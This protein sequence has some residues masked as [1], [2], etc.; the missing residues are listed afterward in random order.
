MSKRKPVFKK[1]KLD[2]TKDN[3]YIVIANDVTEGFELLQT[4]TKKLDEYEIP[5]SQKEC[6]AVC[7]PLPAG[8]V[9]AVFFTFKDLQSYYICHEVSH[10]TH[11]ILQFIGLKLTDDTDEVYAY[12]NDMLFRYCIDF[13]KE[14]KLRIKI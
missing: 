4:V 8:G 12:H 3:F 9:V 13:M 6:P 5:H 2:L 14:N 10:A 7:L 11:H 1:L